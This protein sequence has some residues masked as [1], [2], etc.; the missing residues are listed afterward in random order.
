MKIRTGF[1][2]N[3]SS[4]SFIVA[5]LGPIGENIEN[6]ESKFLD[7]FSWFVDD[8]EDEDEREDAQ[9]IMSR[10]MAWAKEMVSKHAPSEVRFHCVYGHSDE[11]ITPETITFLEGIGI[12]VFDLETY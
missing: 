9:N 7:T 11:G 5:S 12:D 1:V 8:L 10:V 6:L 2:S 4:S 3:S